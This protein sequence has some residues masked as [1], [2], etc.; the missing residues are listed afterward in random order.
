MRVH[1]ALRMISGIFNTFDRSGFDG[2]I[3][4]REFFH[5]FVVRLFDIRKPL[6]IAGLPSAVHANL[7]GI[8]SEFVELSFEIALQLRGTF[9]EWFSFIGHCA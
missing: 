4:I 8:G 7:P 2:L 5:G 9:I 1:R 6:G 3:R